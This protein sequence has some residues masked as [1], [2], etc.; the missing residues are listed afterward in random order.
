MTYRNDFLVAPQSSRPRFV[1]P[2]R[3]N[4]HYWIYYHLDADREVLYI[5]KTNQPDGRTR[6]HETGSDWFQNVVDLIWFGPMDEV[7][8]TAVERELIAVEQPPNNVRHTERDVHAR[9]T[10][11]ARLKSAHARVKRLR[12]ALGRAEENLHRCE[13]AAKAATS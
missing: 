10:P 12:E 4:G 8:A 11:H 7:N 6:S 13:A 9:Q 1:V 5:G 3:V 2:D